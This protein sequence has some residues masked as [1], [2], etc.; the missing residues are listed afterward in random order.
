MC[1]RD[2]Q[3]G[4]SLGLERAEEACIRLNGEPVPMK[5]CG[6]Y[7]DRAISTVPLPPL[8]AGENRLEVTWPYGPRSGLELSLIH[9]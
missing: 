3:E 8:R 7:V 6:W 9:I 2:R 5:D 1:I 4:V